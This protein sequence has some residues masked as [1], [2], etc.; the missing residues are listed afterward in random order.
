MSGKV[1][2]YRSLAKYYDAIYAGKHYGKEAD[3]TVG[4]IR[5]YKKSTGKDLLELACG[6]GLYTKEFKKHGFNVTGL[7]LNKEMLGIAKKRLPK[8]KFIQ[9]NMTSFDLHKK[10]D[11]VACMFSSM[12]YAR[13]YGNLDRM[14]KRIYDHLKPGGVVLLE[15]WLTKDILRKGGYIGG[16]EIGKVSDFEKVARM[17]TS[18]IRGNLTY[19]YIH[20]LI[21]KKGKIIH[22]REKHVMGLF[23]PQKVKNMM[24]STGFQTRITKGKHLGRPLYI[25]IKK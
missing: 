10:F 9:G 14:L 11:V 12:G 8:T 22:V 20:Y 21:G 15:S 3:F 19:T 24:E 25:G 23:D 18:K 7:D 6:T 4:L 2:M 5:K 13:T 17:G 16:P 1:P